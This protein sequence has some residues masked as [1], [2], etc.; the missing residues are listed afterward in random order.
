MIELQTLKLA[1]IVEST[2]NPRKHY[3]THK[4]NEL[5]ESINS[6]G[7]L[8][9]ILVRPL[10]GVRVPETGKGVQFEIIAGARRYRASQI[11]GKE[12]IPA[13]IRQMND[14]EAL[15]SAILENLQRDDLSPLE[16]AEG[17]QSLI[18]HSGL[19]ADDVARKIGKSRSYVFGRLKLLDAGQDVRDALRTGLIGREH[20]QLLARIP[21]T[22]LQA[23]ALKEIIRTNHPEGVMPVRAA[24]EWIRAKY[25]LKIEQAPFDHTDASLSPR[26][27]TICPTRT[28]AEPD[29]FSDV[30]GADMCTDPSCYDNKVQQHHSRR[31]AQLEAAGHQIIEGDDARALMAHA[32]CGPE[33]YARLDNSA[34]S[35][36]TN[37]LRHELAPLLDKGELVPV[38]I[39]NPYKDGDVLACVPEDQVPG[40]LDRAGRKKAAATAK[41][42]RQ[43]Q[44]ERLA[45]RDRDARE[46]KLRME[47]ET[48]W[49]ERLL[50]A[51]VDGVRKEPEQDITASLLRRLSGLL[52]DQIDQGVTVK[53]CAML[54]VEPS[55]EEEAG[56]MG[57][58][59]HALLGWARIGNGLT[60]ADTLNVLNAATG[61]H[62]YTWMSRHPEDEIEDTAHLLG[63][64]ADMPVAVNQIKAQ[65]QAEITEREAPKAPLPLAPAA[66]AG[67]VRGEAKGQ[68]GKGKNRPAG[69]SAQ[70]AHLNA[71]EAMQGIAAA[72][73]GQGVGPASRPDGA[74]DSSGG[75]RAEAGDAAPALAH[76]SSVVDGEAGPQGEALEA[77]GPKA[78]QVGDR[79]RV[80]CDSSI[81]NGKLGTVMAI[82]SQGKATVAVD[83]MASEYTFESGEFELLEGG[84][85]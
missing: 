55:G 23:K 66:Q 14:D 43:E 65:V 10:P 51:V 6:T 50:Q 33:G 41:A 20:A 32:M 37:T 12:T 84:A 9:P 82:N 35:P 72:L 25:M 42:E 63:A 73:Q 69:A 48:T 1:S 17:Y 70:A 3:D 68:K 26:A 53:L 31:R 2:F 7:V 15:E 52:I 75:V 29:I 79:V 49:R 74:A 18:D 77:S 59:E 16:E 76:P 28:G 36:T 56:D 5:A 39:V 45:A 24:G 22:L 30:M 61:A 4:L 38:M 57:I 54:G 11:A 71:Q 44:D 40:L 34:D 47:Y 80:S 46:T 83:G 64:V 81:F 19:S 27:C 67:G 78:V 21:S 13:I 85:A 58:H 62:W 8:Q 60:P